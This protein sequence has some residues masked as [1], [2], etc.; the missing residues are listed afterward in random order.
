MDAVI[1]L[2]SLTPEAMQQIVAMQLQ[3]CRQM[4]EEQGL[5]L[6]VS[7]EAREESLCGR[8]CT[9]ASA[10][11]PTL[12]LAKYL[13]IP[14]QADAAPLTPVTLLVCSAGRAQLL[15]CEEA[16]Q[17]WPKRGSSSRMYP[18][19]HTCDQNMPTALAGRH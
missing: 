7:S 14:H 1:Q 4:L 9:N 18:W 3:E 10:C 8:G 16:C 17:S 15:Y 5:Q 11:T 12:Y 19:T 13:F 6:K 2:E